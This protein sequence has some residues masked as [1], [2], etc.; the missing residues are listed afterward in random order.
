MPGW[1]AVVCR[2]IRLLAGAAGRGAPAKVGR[3]I[4]RRV[5]GNSPT[6]MLTIAAAGQFVKNFFGNSA[7]P[8]TAGGV[9]PRRFPQP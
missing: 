2:R 6:N 4:R 1:G 3:F 8:L 7:G 9:C 5:P